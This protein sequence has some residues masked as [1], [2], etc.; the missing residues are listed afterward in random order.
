[1]ATKSVI[2]IT[3]P[4]MEYGAKQNGVKQIAP[5]AN[6]AIGEDDSHRIPDAR[7]RSASGLG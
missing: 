7:L 3:L 1:V 6:S 5:V 2:P 4:F